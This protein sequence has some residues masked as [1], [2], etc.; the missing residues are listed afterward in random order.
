[1]TDAFTPHLIARGAGDLVTVSSVIAFL[2][3]PLMPNY[4]ASKAGVHALPLDGFLDEVTELNSADPTP[5]EVLVKGVHM[6][7]FAERDGTYAELVAKRSAVFA[8]GAMRK[9]HDVL[10]Y[11]APG[12]RSRS[13][14]TTNNSTDL[15]AA[16][17]N[18]G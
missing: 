8:I 7:R 13:R 9:R 12:K 17:A 6:H 5:Q 10:S 4:A 15:R 3:F 2:P 16:A 14:R 11:T 18:S 1:M